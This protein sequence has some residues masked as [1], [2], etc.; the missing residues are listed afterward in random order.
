M[1]KFAEIAVALPVETAFTYAVPEELKAEARLGKR[2]LVPFGRR[3]VTGY[4][5]GLTASAPAEIANI[6]PI[7]DILDSEALFDEKRLRFL[8]WVSSYYF[9]PLGEVLSL[10]HPGAGQHQEHAR[11]QGRPL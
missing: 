7:I 5:L 11:P 2:V 1:K 3:T 9:A 10:T 6:K 4:I 8:K